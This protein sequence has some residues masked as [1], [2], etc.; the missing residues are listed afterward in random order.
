METHIQTTHGMF[1]LNA[2]TDAK[3]AARLAE[4]TFPQ[5]ETLDLIEALGAK[6]VVDVGAHIGTVS[7][8][9]AKLGKNVV[10]FEP[11][12][13]S[14]KYLIR[15][16]E[17]NGV[18]ID[19]RNKGLA[20]TPGRAHSVARQSGNAGAHTLE[21]GDE[22][23]VSTLDAEIQDADF[24][25]IDVEGMELAV[26]KGGQALL[27]RSRPA[28][29]FEVN[30]TALRARRTLLASLAKF[31]R[32]HRYRF[33]FCADHVLYELPGL[34]PAALLVTPRSMLF[35]GP[36][37]LFDVLALAAESRAPYPA[38]SRMHAM[39]YLLTRYVKLQYARFF[40]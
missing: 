17:L 34:T 2:H 15:N 9:L 33:Y 26:L 29:Y 32:A 12:P 11:S 21:A 13:E 7:I 27:E 3:M 16:A 4:E 38:R 24:I 25:K 36:S 6:R 20:D 30:L 10:A 31:F 35:G 23:K 14:F 39:L 40:H 37:A 22:I 1:A 18:T 28:V 5:Q 19:A 8:P